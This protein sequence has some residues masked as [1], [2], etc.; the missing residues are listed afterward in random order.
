MLSGPG[1]GWGSGKVFGNIGGPVALKIQR[2]ESSVPGQ[3][4]SHAVSR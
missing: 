3:D 4:R 2:K 1:V